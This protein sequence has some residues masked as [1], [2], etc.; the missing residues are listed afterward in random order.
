MSDTQSPTIPGMPTDAAAQL[1]AALTSKV[2]LVDENGDPV[3]S[4]PRVSREAPQPEEARRR[5]VLKWRARIKADK[6]HHEKAFKRMHWNQGFTHGRQWGT[7][8]DLLVPTG[9]FG[10]SKKYVANICLRHVQQRTAELYAQNPKVVFR[11]TERMLATVWDGDMATLAAAQQQMQQ[12][13]LNQ[14]LVQQANPGMP[15]PPPGS[16]PPGL[17]PQAAAILADFKNVQIYDKMLRRVGKTLQLLWDYNVKEQSFPFKPMMKMTVRRAIVTGVGYVKLGFQRAMQMNPEIET[18]IA[19]MQERLSTIERLADDIADD[20]IHQD[21]AEVEQLRLAIQGLMNEPQI[22]VR[23][24]LLFDYPDSTSIIPDRKCKNL[25]GF[26][27]SDWVTQEYLLTPDQIQAIYGVDVGSGFTTYYVNERTGQ[28]EASD[29]GS[30]QGRGDGEGDEDDPRGRAMVW[31]TYS[32]TDGLVYI[33]CDGYP[34]F[35]REPAPPDVVLDRFFPWFVMVLNEGYH[36]A[37]IFPKSDIDLMRDMQLELNRARQGLR[38]HRRANRPKMAVAA[39]VLDDSDLEHL[40]DHPANAVLEIKGLAPGQKID[41]LLQPVKMPPI[42]DA[43]YDT[44]GAFEDV[45]R[46]L[47]QDQASTGQTTDATA[48]EAAVAQSAQHTD[49]SSCLDDQDDMLS[50]IATA[51]GKILMMEVSPETVQRVIGPGAIWPELSRLEILE[52]IY[53]TVEAG[54][55]GRPNKQQDVMNAQILFPMLQRVPGISPEWMARELIKRMDDRLDLTDA[56]VEGMPS[57]DALNRIQG[58]VASPPPQDPVNPVPSTAPNTTPMLGVPG[59]APPPG[60]PPG[61]GGPPP[62][63]G[64]PP[65]GPGGPGGPPRPAPRPVPRPAPRPAPA[66]AGAPT[67]GSA[68]PGGGLA[69]DPTAQ[70]PQGGQNAPAV[71]PVNGLLGPRQ[72]PAPGSNGILPRKMPPQG[73]VPVP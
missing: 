9:D 63:P 70:G 66:P 46:V 67:G 55:T 71:N 35:L 30:S 69:H 12:A 11:K 64:G 60:A 27:G 57:M 32:R 20:E 28:S 7:E 34:D 36:E 16:P 24:G 56:F 53:L 58:T 62:G 68:P 25:R 40:A 52:N 21:A 26:L 1:V 42:D 61:P 18:R 50:E 6:K 4:P 72:P 14:A 13:A 37:E 51:A 8:D 22:I 49:L 73:G 3:A 65:P 2:A 39:G 41:E 43:L 17:N 5:L 19:D 38:E 23:E 33:S 54:S 59:G 47:G 44:N 10:D 29:G 48:T 15:A 45:L 31:E